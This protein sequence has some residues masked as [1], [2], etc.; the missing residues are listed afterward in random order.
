MGGFQ[1]ILDKGVECTEQ[2]HFTTLIIVKNWATVQQQGDWSNYGCF[3]TAE[4][5]KSI[6]RILDSELVGGILWVVEFQLILVRGRVWLFVFYLL[7]A[8]NPSIF[9]D[10]VQRIEESL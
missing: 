8:S 3:H 6:S 2:T 4:I 10:Q 7:K 5:C 9:Y 1:R